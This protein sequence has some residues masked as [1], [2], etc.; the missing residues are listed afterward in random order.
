M[1]HKIFALDA[2]REV[3][4]YKRKSARHLRLTIDPRGN[5][6]VSIPTWVPYQAGL[7]FAV[8]KQTWIKANHQTKGALKNGQ[9]VGK[10]HHLEFTKDI[11]KTKPTSR[12]LANT[13]LISYPPHL[14]DDNPAV[15]AVA[16]RACLRAL[17]QQAE[18]LLPQRLHNLAERLDFEYESVSVKNLKSRWGS[19]DQDKNIILSIYLMQVPWHLIDYVLLHELTHTKVM[20]HGP[21]FWEAIERS[22]P[23]AKTYRKQLKSYQPVL[24][25][26]D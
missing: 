25:A 7:D 16:E 9:P 1:S 5:I 2:E 23:G 8:S 18:S 22:L 15:Q 11:S 20:R 4:V 6:K 13:I 10:A 19:C 17:K 26:I 24:M 14:S 12:T 21:P 3:T